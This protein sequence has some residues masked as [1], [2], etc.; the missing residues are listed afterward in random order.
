MMATRNRLPLYER[1]ERAIV[2]AAKVCGSA[3]LLIGFIGA[4]WAYVWIA[5]ALLNAPEPTERCF[6]GATA[7]MSYCRT[8]GAWE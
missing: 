6:T 8:Q 7:E 1:I 3:L 4:L 2:V 5:D